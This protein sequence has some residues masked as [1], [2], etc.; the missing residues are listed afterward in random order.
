[1]APGPSGQS[2]AIRLALTL[3]L[4]ELTPFNQDS[5]GV[6]TQTH[7][8]VTSP[9]KLWGSETEMEA[10]G[11]KAQKPFIGEFRPIGDPV[12]KAGT[13]S[14]RLCWEPVSFQLAR[15]FWQPENS[16]TAGGLPNRGSPS[17]PRTSWSSSLKTPLFPE[18]HRE[19]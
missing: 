3:A 10:E 17:L 13:P 16:K 15:G 5:F 8:S 6:G 1:M 18:S 14:T 11:P 12:P 4:G 7:G 9:H 2:L 19:V